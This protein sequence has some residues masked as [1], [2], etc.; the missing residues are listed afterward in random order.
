MDQIMQGLVGLSGEDW[1]DLCVQVLRLEH[2]ANLV[3][4]PDKG[5]DGGLEAYTL[6]GHAFQ[7]YSP[8]E[9]LQPK[10]R[11]E[12]QRDKATEDIG[13]FIN[14]E[15]KLKSLIGDH[16]KIDRWILLCPLIDMKEL[17]G[18]CT[19]L[20]TRVRNS[21]LPYADPNIHVICQTMEA[22]EMSYKRLVNSQLTRLH[23]PSLSEPDYSTIESSQIETMH[24]KLQKVPV[25]RNERARNAHIQKLLKAYVES[26]EYRA[27]IKDNYTEI[28]SGL[29]SL[30]EDLEFRLDT[31]YM[32]YPDGPQAKLAK[33]YEET[34][35]RIRQ[36][37]TES[38]LSQ[39]RTLSH[40][41]V[42]DWLMRCPL[43]FYDEAS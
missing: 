23:L 10:K 30:L 25:M 35:K 15:K 22:Y 7:C 2:G 38:S 12:N 8:K 17:A 40:G 26:Q 16:V 9:P 36:A 34:E 3:V 21:D 5:G 4:L 32:V 31:E 42:A 13:K 11:Y 1:Q 14:N 29:E 24:E 6:T 19:T 28:D 43:D 20:T 39:S 18:H 37:A 41:Q 27:Y 33:I